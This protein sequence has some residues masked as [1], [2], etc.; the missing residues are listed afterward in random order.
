MAACRLAE[1]LGFNPLCEAASC[2]HKARHDIRVLKPVGSSLDR[3]N[4]MM[5]AVRCMCQELDSVF[6]PL[7]STVPEHMIRSPWNHFA[8]ISVT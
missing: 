4:M 3:V 7:R 6:P 2:L 8:A 1:A 5:K